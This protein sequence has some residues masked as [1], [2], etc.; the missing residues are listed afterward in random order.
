MFHLLVFAGLAALLLVALSP[1]TVRRSGA[2]VLQA[3]VTYQ[4]TLALRPDMS[5]PALVAALRQMPGV[6]EAIGHGRSI[7]FAYTSPTTETVQ[8]GTM[9]LGIA[10][11][12]SVSRSDGKAL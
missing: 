7:V 10:T 11:L 3:G 8:V 12:T 9:F 2:V 6:V 1:T 4:M 5:A